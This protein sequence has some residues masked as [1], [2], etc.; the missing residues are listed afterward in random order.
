LR[1]QYKW[2]ICRVDCSYLE[3]RPL[4]DHFSSV[5]ECFRVFTELHPSCIEAALRVEGYC[6]RDFRSLF[7]MHYMQQMEVGS[8]RFGQI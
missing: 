6:L 1:G 7:L 2:K 8:S 5:L 3:K 4:F